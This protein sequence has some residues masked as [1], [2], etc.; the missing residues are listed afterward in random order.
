MPYFGTVSRRNLAGCDLRLQ[1][2]FNRAIIFF[3]CKVICGH[4]GRESQNAAFN[5]FPQKSKKRWPDSKH[6]KKPSL[7]VDVLPYPIE[8]GDEKRMYYFAG[9]VMMI[10]K[11]KG[12]KLR[13]GGDWDSDTEVKDQTF[14][15]L[16]HFELVGE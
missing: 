2:I 15:D 7:A 12:I 6:N 3:D 11:D 8:Y 13:W 14:F 5:D 9:F 10:A 16:A 1:E 4:R